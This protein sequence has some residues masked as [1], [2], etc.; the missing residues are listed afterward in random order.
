MIQLVPFKVKPV[1][2]TL[3]EDFDDIDPGAY[4][5]R[6]QSNTNKQMGLYDLIESIVVGKEWMVVGSDQADFLLA[7]EGEIAQWYPREFCEVV[8]L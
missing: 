6:V 8:K 2:V 4:Q 1:P 3:F 5:R 7:R